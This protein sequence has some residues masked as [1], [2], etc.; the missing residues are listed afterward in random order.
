MSQ[1]AVQLKFPLPLACT[2]HPIQIP[3]MNRLLLAA[4]L[5]SSSAF[6]H[7]P[8]I[9]LNSAKQEPKQPIYADLML[10]NHGNNHRDF[11]LAGK[12]PLKGS[13]LSLISSNGQATDLKPDIVDAGSEE[14]EGYWSVKIPTQPSGLHC[15]AHLYDAVVTYAPKRVLKGAKSYFITLPDPSGQ[16]DSFTK[17]LGH[18]LEIVPLV[19]PTTLS[20]GDPVKVKVLFKGMPLADAV[21]SCIPR[22]VE[23]ETEFDPKHEARTNAGGEAE[24]PVATANRYLIVAHR[25]APEET[26]DGYSA[27]TEY[28]ATLTLIVAEK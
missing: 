16:T 21:V 4:L 24:L 10:G 27:G 5:V 22:G 15:V 17:P 2:R 3:A 11:L 14:K 26:G 25:K 8:W 9:Q 19:N 6:A 1:W 7:D 23:L 20:A 18:P 12:I 13:T 28:A